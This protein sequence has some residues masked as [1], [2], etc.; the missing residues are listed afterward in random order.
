MEMILEKLG[1]TYSYSST[2]INF[3]KEFSD[4]VMKWAEKNINKN[5][6]NNEEG[7]FEDQIH[8]TVLYGI[9]DERHEDAEK[10]ISNFIPFKI[11]LGKIS[12]LSKDG[13]YDVLK[14]E[15]VSDDLTKLHYL[16]EKN[17][18][19]KNSFPVYKP[20][21]TIAY[22]KPN[23]CDHLIGSK[24]FADK[25]FKIYGIYFSSNVGYKKLMRFKRK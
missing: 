3:N 4:S 14:I 16:I 22:V 11:K 18:P 12:K 8:C 23:S 6:L 17:I 7:G 15:V 24:I 2:E 5:F 9:K 10:L 20:H 1:Q 19:N 25:K 21:V 13:E